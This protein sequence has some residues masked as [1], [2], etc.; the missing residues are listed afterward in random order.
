MTFD[1]RSSIVTIGPLEPA[2]LLSLVIASMVAWPFG[3]ALA[4]VTRRLREPW[5]RAFYIAPLW[6]MV[7]AALFILPNLVVAGAYPLLHPADRDAMVCVAMVW[8]TF[9]LPALLG[10]W[11]A[12]G[13]L[14]GSR[15]ATSSSQVA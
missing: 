9:T 3:R 1:L 6:L 12:A 7:G 13:R 15:I 11:V 10:Y 5:R 4:A 14:R 2:L 8:P